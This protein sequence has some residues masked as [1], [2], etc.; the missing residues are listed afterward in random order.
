MDPEDGIDLLLK[1]AYPLDDLGRKEPHKRTLASSIAAELGYLAIALDQ[2]GATIRRKI[3]TLERYLHIYLGHRHRL[4]KSASKIFAPEANVITTWEIPF[5]RIERRLSTEYKDAVTILHIFAF[6]HF[7]SISEKTF[8]MFWMSNEESS[9]SMP[10]LLRLRSCYMDEAHARL[11]SAIGILCDYSIIDYDGDRQVCMMHPV[12]HRWARSRLAETDQD[13]LWLNRTAEL[14]TRC[15]SVNLES[16]GRDFRRTLLPHI[17]SCVELLRDSDTILPSTEIRANQVERFAS[18]YADN[19]RWNQAIS[20]Q[21]GI[22]QFRTRALGIEPTKTLS[23]L[24]DRYH[25][26]SGICS[27]CNKSSKFST[28]CGN[29]AGG[30]VLNSPTGATSSSLTISATASL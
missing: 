14:L 23:E 16:S 2:A 17:D 19:G 6:L 25:T 24:S 12:V 11:R 29:G 13:T 20:W 1:S 26:A 27:K 5:Q 22:V 30:Y 3:Y 7:E 9:P 21:K 18:V 4:L 10:S 8:H 15:I 28:L